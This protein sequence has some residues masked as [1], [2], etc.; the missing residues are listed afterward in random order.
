VNCRFAGRRRGTCAILC[1]VAGL[2]LITAAPSL[3]AQEPSER[4][5]AAMDRIGKW[6]IA[7]FA[8]FAIGLGYFLVRYSPRFFNARS[9][10]IRKAIEDATGLKL[11]ADYRYSEID[12]KM[13]SLADEVQRMREQAQKEL[14][15][16]HERFRQ[17]AEAEIEHIHRNLSNEIEAL[18]RQ[19]TNQVRRH[20]AEL[21]LGLAERRLTDRFRGPEPEDSIQDFVHLI[22]RSRN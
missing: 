16:E 10:D 3:K 19:A 11:Q 7:N 21:A 2:F 6:K 20:A 1:L 4:E 5:V 18:R 12:R 14:D 9:A 17:E 13:A 22:E 15:R 8:I